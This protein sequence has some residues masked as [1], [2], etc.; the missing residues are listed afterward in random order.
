MQD[1]YLKFDSPAAAQSVLFTVPEPFE[2]A[3]G[4]L[5]VPDEEPT[6]RYLNIDQIG[7]IYEPT[8]ETIEH[9]GFQMPVMQALPGWHVNVRLM[10]AEDGAPLEAYRVFPTS[11][12]RVWG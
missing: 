9:E 8:G 10:P 11:P 5:V 2:D 4:V 12:Q 1:L 7:T 6:P 3:D